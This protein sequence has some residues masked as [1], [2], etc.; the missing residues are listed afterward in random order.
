MA[1]S[2]TLGWGHLFV[3]DFSMSVDEELNTVLSDTAFDISKVEPDPRAWCKWIVHLLKALE[4]RVV[5][6]LIDEYEAMLD[7]LRF[8]RNS[9]GKPQKW[10]YNCRKQYNV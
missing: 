10:A 7:E 1:S 3:G 9:R 4:D 2:H 6:V 8:S 5:S